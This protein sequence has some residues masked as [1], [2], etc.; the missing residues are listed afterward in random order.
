[1]EF[2]EPGTGVITFKQP[3]E[4]PRRC[5]IGDSWQFDLAFALLC[6]LHGVWSHEEEGIPSK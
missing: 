5:I 6:L 3:I 4:S 2:S 1:M